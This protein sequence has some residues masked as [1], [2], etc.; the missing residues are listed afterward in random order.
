NNTNLHYEVNPKYFHNITE[1]FDVN[2][3]DEELMDFE[4]ALENYADRK[5]ISVSDGKMEGAER[6][7][8]VPSQHRIVLRH[9]LGETE[10]PKVLLHELAHGEMH[11]VKKSNRMPTPVKE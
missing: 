11:N 7:Y 5:G 6:G 1:N 3:T 4:T 9:T 10:R 8:Y 2:Y